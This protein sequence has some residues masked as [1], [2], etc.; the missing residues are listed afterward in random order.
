MPGGGEGLLKAH[1]Q[2]LVAVESER[3]G[4]GGLVHGRGERRGR[5]RKS[6]EAGMKLLSPA[7]ITGN[8]DRRRRCHRGSTFASL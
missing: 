5:R 6:A 4:G 3:R 8:A 2:L 1:K 7:C